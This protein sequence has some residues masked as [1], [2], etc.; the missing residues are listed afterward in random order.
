M[1]WFVARNGDS[2]GPFSPDTLMNGARTGRLRKD[3]WVWRTGLDDWVPA[4]SIAD[5]WSQQNSIS[6]RAITVKSPVP[7]KPVDRITGRRRVLLAPFFLGLFS[8][9]LIT[10]GMFLVKDWLLE[11]VVVC[12]S[13]VSNVATFW[14][15]R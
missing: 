8:S 11:Y 6:S 1:G 4:S 5:L 12:Y 3:D 13:M 15:L 2:F 14:T 7:F 9:I 10:A